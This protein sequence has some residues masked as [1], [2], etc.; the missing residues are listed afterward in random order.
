MAVY[1]LANPLSALVSFIVGGWVNEHYGWRVTFFVLGFPALLVAVVVRFTIKE[2]RAREGKPPEAT[3]L[4][5]F[6]E[7]LVVLWRHRSARHLAAAIILLFM[8]GI[9]LGQ[10]FAAFMIRSHHM[11]TGELGTWLG[12][13]LGCG[14]IVGIVLGGYV[15]QYERLADERSQMRLCAVMI[16]ALVPCS[17][18]FLLLPRPGL[19]LLAL[20]PWAVVLNYFFGS[21]FALMQRLVREDMR[22]TTM[23]IVMLLA[24]LIGMGAGPQLVGIL[25]DALAP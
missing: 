13:I 22:A 1:W 6:Q 8:M 17:V 16:A 20:I 10:W 24:N 15:P 14:G 5:A 18:A 12:L 7:V 4:P 2:P 19:A 3:T 25:S 23:A 9:G 21:A 11:S